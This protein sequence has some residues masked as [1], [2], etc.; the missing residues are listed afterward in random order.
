MAAIDRRVGFLFL[1]FMLLLG[2]ALMRAT[3]LGAFKADSLQHAASS[4]QI[5]QTQ[6]PATRGAITDRT[7]VQ[8]AISQSAADV[9]ADP[10]LIK[11]PLPAAQQL[12]PLLHKPMLTVLSE[13]SRHTGYMPLAHK[14][15]GAEAKQIAGLRIDGITTTP[16]VKRI[17]PRT[18]A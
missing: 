4:Q 3:Y 5:V 13:L 9:V 7:G 8:L 14:V 11:H 18:W 6:I 15:S 2:V 1:G 17:Y 16:D 10:F 12:A